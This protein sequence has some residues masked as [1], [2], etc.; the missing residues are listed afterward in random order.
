M[1]IR[2]N[3]CFIKDNRQ[4]GNKKELT[5]FSSELAEMA[6]CLDLLT[7]KGGKRKSICEH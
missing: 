3:N 6:C 4:N 1:N 5:Y 2:L 7:L